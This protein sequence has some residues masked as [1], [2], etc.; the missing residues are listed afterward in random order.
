MLRKILG[1]RLKRLIVLSGNKL[2][3][4]IAY[5][6][7]IHKLYRFSIYTSKSVLT[8][9]VLNVNFRKSSKRKKNNN[10]NVK[11]DQLVNKVVLFFVFPPP[12]PF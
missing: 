4:N 5:E 9:T 12:R 1:I 3:P 11:K 7:N 2:A 8:M 10:T 6:H